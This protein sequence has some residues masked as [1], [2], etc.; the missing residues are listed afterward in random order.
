MFEYKSIFGASDDIGLAYDMM[1][2]NYIKEEEEE[3]SNKTTGVDE[4]DA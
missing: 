4:E 1:V 2:L 3:D